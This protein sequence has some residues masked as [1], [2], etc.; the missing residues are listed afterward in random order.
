MKENEL[1]YISIDELRLSQLYLNQ[2]KVDKVFAWFNPL[3]I[4]EYDPLPVHDFSKK[5][6]YVLTDGHTRAYVLYKSGVGHIPVVIDNDEY[7][8]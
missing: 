6:K 3:R 5:G 1:F 8:M 4:D 2:D 7:D